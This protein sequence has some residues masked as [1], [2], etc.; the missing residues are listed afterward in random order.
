MVLPKWSVDVQD[1]QLVY[2]DTNGF[3][4]SPLWDPVINAPGPHYFVCDMWFLGG[5]HIESMNL[6]SKDRKFL[7]TEKYRTQTIPFTASAGEQ[8][9]LFTDEPVPVGDSEPAAP[10]AY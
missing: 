10:G 1:G 3:M 4:A 2:T 5:L 9:W 8:Y 7:F 6:R